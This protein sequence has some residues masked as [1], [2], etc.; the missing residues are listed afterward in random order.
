MLIWRR[1]IAIRSIYSI[2]WREEGGLFLSRMIILVFN[3]AVRDELSV[4]DKSLPLTPSGMQT[5]T[6]DDE[7]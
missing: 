1:G 5:E 4:K 2:E 3:E 7:Q 6:V